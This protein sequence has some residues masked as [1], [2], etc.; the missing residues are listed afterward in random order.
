MASIDTLPA[1]RRAVLE[2]VLRRGRSY[3]EIAGLLSIDRAGVRQRAL[4]A[5]DALGPQ[6]RVPPERRGLITDYLL[7]AL[8][9]PVAAEV[10]EHLAQSAS[11]RAWA[12]SVSSELEG[13]AD[14]PLPEIPGEA[15]TRPAQA[16][17][18]AEERSAG[19]PVS[20]SAPIGAGAP[21]AA[22]A[23]AAA[24]APVAAAA[25]TDPK[26]P[27]QSS[28]VGGAVLL[29]GVA[30]I[31]L[32]VVLILVLPGGGGSKH[33]ANASRPSHAASSSGSSTPAASSTTSTSARVL[34]RITLTPPTG[35]STPVGLAEVLRVQGRTGIAI[36]AQGVAANS[37][38]PPNAYAVWLYNSPADTQRLGF[39]NPAVGTN[40]Q[41]RTAGAL[42]KNA[43][44]FQRLLVTLET[45]SN[46]RTPGRIV[47]EGT[48][49]GL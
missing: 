43:S 44:H 39:V 16:M 19:A 26:P 33:L 38:R 6:T 29:A 35:G 12:R 34:S 1:D 41:L 25:A 7:G 21:V 8:P 20:A 30:A 18:A 11:E 4:A 13:L 46:P 24:D 9:E 37:K 42:P 14:G 31:V 2:L 28:R 48:L 17:P 22:D 5:L 15:Q 49:T 32:A 3:D 23:P 40:G 10:R 45:T 36:A 47:L 27:R